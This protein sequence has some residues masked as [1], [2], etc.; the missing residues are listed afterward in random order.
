LQRYLA[1]QGLSD[2]QIAFQVATLLDDGG[3]RD[4]FNYFVPKLPPEAKE[5]LLVSG[6]AVGTELAVALEYGFKAV[7]GSEV[8]AEYVDIANR[9]FSNTAAARA[10]LISRNELPFRDGMFS[11]VASGHII[12]HTPSP[13]FYLKEH[14]RVLKPNGFMFLEFPDRYHGIEL[15]TGLPSFEWLPVLARNLVLYLLSHPWSGLPGE[16]KLRYQDIAKTL[17]PIGTWQIRLY[18]RMLRWQRQ[19]IPARIVHVYAPHPGYI[20]ML[21]VR[22]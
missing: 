6:C 2:S 12:E 4:R 5:S 13:C 10:V 8:S 9:R 3:F 1:G 15:H 20:R 17:K 18:L 14:L 16:K 22:D 11:C 7:V 21:I 19:K